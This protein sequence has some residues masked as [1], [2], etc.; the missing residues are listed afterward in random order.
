MALPAAIGLA[1]VLTFLA[2]LLWLDSYKLVRAR[3]VVATVAAGGAVAGAAYL[4][5]AALQE[6]LSVD[7]RTY[8]RYG[9]PV[10]EEALKGA[11]LAALI[12]THRVGF[13]VDAAILGFAAGAGFA[14]VENLHYLLSFPD[15][16]PGTWILRGFGT[17]I[18]HGGTAAIFA[19]LGMAFA[20]RSG[21]AEPR[22]F[23]AGLALA[24]ALHSAFNHFLEVP[25]V[26]AA[27]I[28]LVLPPLFIAVFERSERALGEWLG[29]GFDEDA[30]M[31]ELIESGQLADS[32]TGRYL[33]SLR[34]RFPGP[35]VADLLCYVRVHTE[36]VL[37]AKGLMLMRES[38]FDAPIDE[39]TRARFEEIRYLESSIGPS[40]LRVVRPMLSM[41]HRDLWQL[42]MLKGSSSS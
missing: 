5:N 14:M 38:G 4:A 9:A 16:G 35:V 10:V 2:A 19:V 3:A 36:L 39:P 1:P 29:R 34:G 33:E 8:T 31:L 15:A 32:P 22:G 25:L 20:E 27:G 13:L 26:S 40:G 23:L 7:L 41:S 37:R 6:F 11:L 24:V 21:R 28:A 12:A 42:Y 18:M 17:A 30:R